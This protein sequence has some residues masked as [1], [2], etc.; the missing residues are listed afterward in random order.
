MTFSVLKYESFVGDLIFV[1]SDVRERYSTL[2]CNLWY[3]QQTLDGRT[4][5]NEENGRLQ[6]LGTIYKSR[7]DFNS[8]EEAMKSIFVD[9]L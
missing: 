8:L 5:K 1:V 6:T 4:T 7:T 2:L 9:L 3:S